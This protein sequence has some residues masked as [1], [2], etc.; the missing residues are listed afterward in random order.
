[1]NTQKSYDDL[2]SPKNSSTNFPHVFEVANDTRKFEIDLY[3]KRTNYFIL[4][5]GAIFT[6]YTTLQIKS[7]H[8]PFLSNISYIL[9]CLGI[10]TTYTWFLSLKGSKYWQENWELHVKYSQNN[11]IGPLFDYVKVVDKYTYP[12][13]TS[14]D[15]F[16]AYPYSVSKLNMFLSITIFGIWIII[17]LFV[18]NT[19]VDDSLYN[20]IL[21]KSDVVKTTLSVG[22]LIIIILARKLC[23]S[24]FEERMTLYSNS[25]CKLFKLK[26]G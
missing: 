6:G 25:N 15:I 14:K 3:W 4:F 23:V 5:I 19:G 17:L 2:F 1:M 11:I 22:T 13:S 8:T 24:S 21:S 18:S 12:P 20:S 26:T 10:I 7:Y 9:N 16:K